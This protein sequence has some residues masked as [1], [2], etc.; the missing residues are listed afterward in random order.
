MKH[1]AIAALLAAIPFSSTAEP[2][3]RGE[4]ALELATRFV[5]GEWVHDMEF[6]SGAAFHAENTMQFGPGENSILANG[7]AGIVDGDGKET[8][9]QLWIDPATE[10]LMYQTLHDDGT[11]ARGTIHL[12]DENTLLWDWVE[13]TASNKVSSYD[14]TTEFDGDDRYIMKVYPKG[15][16]G[17]IDVQEIVFDR[18]ELN[19]T[20][21]SEED[22]AG[23]ESDRSIL[24]HQ[25]LIEAP[26]EIL[27]HMISTQ[28][29]T[30]KWMAPMTQVDFRLGG[31]IKTTYDPKSGIGGPGT[32][33]HT[34]LSY[35]PMR[36]V[37]MQFKAPDNAPKA[38]IAESTWWIIRL[39]PRGAD[40]TEVTV[41][42]IGFGESE[43]WE[44]SR[45]LFDQGNN[46][47]LLQLKNAAEKAATEGIEKITLPDGSTIE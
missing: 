46:L 18:Q 8:S 6:P 19:T 43:E 30:Q 14:I 24:R 22:L 27:W 16:V 10:N 28:R 41:S 45:K 32:I 9:S 39:D 7:A 40:K 20:V 13:T 33:V 35:E 11:V 5:G 44:H 26:V 29:G 36:S 2:E 31:T 37:A 38:K 12:H 17:E 34:I 21:Y 4:A 47:T 23:P 15:K 25:A 1:I 3:K 42:M